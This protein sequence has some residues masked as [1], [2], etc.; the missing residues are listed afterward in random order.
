MKFGSQEMTFGQVT[1]IMG[2]INMTPDSFSN[3]GCY[4]DAKTAHY[5]AL[6]R[7]DQMIQE[8]T[9][10]IDIGGESTRPGADKISASEEINRVIPIIKTLAKKTSIPI[11]IDT[12]KPDV[13]KRALDAGAAIINNIMGSQLD[14][15]LLLMTKKY[16]ASIVLMHI[17]GNPQTMQQKISYDQLT[18][19]IIGILQNSMDQCLE[20]GI[21]R[22]KIIVDP[23]IG[24]G[25]TV[26]QNLEI[27][28]R[29]N[30]FQS[31]DR[32]ILIGPS[33]K[34]FI[35]KVLKLEVTD[36]LIGTVTSVCASIMRG[37]HIVRIHDVKELKQAVILTDAIVN[38]QVNN[39]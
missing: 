33:R 39:N 32:P 15:N 7:A 5:L 24:F 25:K 26:E 31:L 30:L 35:G 4:V 14:R 19:D 28:N 16:N 18:N 23:G 21:S 10:I 17:Q 20:T 13:A 2:I 29:L 8:G 34:S 3:D 36:R 1:R 12:Y 9:D 38:E 11:S 6:N 27:I 22:D 37:A